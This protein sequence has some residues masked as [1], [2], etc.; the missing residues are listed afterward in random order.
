M[1]TFQADRE[2]DVRSITHRG[3]DGYQG[4]MQGRRQV[5]VFVGPSLL[6]QLGTDTDLPWPTLR[7]ALDAID[8]GRLEALAPGGT[9][10]SGQE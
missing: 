10:P 5:V 1:L 8:V 3:H 9:G 4:R 6:V 2:E 7:G